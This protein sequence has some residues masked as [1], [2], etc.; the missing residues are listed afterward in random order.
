MVAMVN[1]V[2]NAFYRETER[3]LELL[4]SGRKGCEAGK[5]LGSGREHSV[6]PQLFSM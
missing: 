6:F 2:F 3:E 4:E 1:A 5:L